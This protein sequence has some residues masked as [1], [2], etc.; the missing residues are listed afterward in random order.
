M[1][2]IIVPHYIV[3]FANWSFICHCAWNHRCYR[4]HDAYLNLPHS[5][6]SLLLHFSVQWDQRVF[7]RVGQD[8]LMF[9]LVCP[10]VWKGVS[11][12]PSNYISIMFSGTQSCHKCT[13]WSSPTGKFWRCWLKESRN[14]I[15]FKPNSNCIVLSGCA[16]IFG[17]EGHFER[18]KNLIV[19]ECN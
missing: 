8:Y 1:S 17:S 12:T 6:N 18:N 7:K 13:H 11:V 15:F 10:D 3:P 2:I 19:L 9:Y 14:V 16:C 4:L 5:T